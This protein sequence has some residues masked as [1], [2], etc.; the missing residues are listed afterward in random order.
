MACYTTNCWLEYYSEKEISG[1]LRTSLWV[2]L[3]QGK[4][5]QDIHNYSTSF[6]IVV[7]TSG[8]VEHVSVLTQSLLP[9]NLG[10]IRRPSPKFYISTMK[11]IIYKWR[12]F[13]PPAN[14]STRGKVFLRSL[15]PMLKETSKRRGKTVWSL[16][17]QS[18]VTLNVTVHIT[19]ITK[20]L[21]VCLET[22]SAL[23]KEYSSV[24]SVW[25]VS[26]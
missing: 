11:T 6:R 10:R 3:L 20:N 14:L 15:H 23:K 9:I 2:I 12:K 17:L 19:V 5:L 4:R 25:K 16:L 8:C 22:T 21:E 24:T 1:E 7:G 18:S 26:P 13:K